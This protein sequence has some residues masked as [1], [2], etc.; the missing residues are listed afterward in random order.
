MYL[1]Q[2]E[3]G[4]LLCSIVAICLYIFRPIGNVD[5]LVLL[6]LIVA[7]MLCFTCIW[8]AGRTSDKRIDAT[9][10]K[11]QKSIDELNKKLTPP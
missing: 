8:E 5:V 11:I 4:A 10:K 2:L 3:M 6:L 7:A 9:K 1:I